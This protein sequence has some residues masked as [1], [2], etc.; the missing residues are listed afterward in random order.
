MGMTMDLLEV[1]WMDGRD[2]EE[3]RQLV[4]LQPGS[5]QKVTLISHREEDSQRL[6][7]HGNRMHRREEVT[8]CQ[9]ELAHLWDWS[10]GNEPQGFMAF[11]TR[12]RRWHNDQ[13]VTIVGT[14]EG[15]C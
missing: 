10:V 7:K 11:I 12:P 6:Q 5:L 13:A 14:W 4:Q 8:L 1:E 2:C 9:E 3:L 15:F